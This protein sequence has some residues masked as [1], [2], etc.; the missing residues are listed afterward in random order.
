LLEAR[1]SQPYAFGASWTFWHENPQ[2]P[3]FR[4]DPRTGTVRPSRAR[5]DYG[6]VL[7]HPVSVAWR[8]LDKELYLSCFQFRQFSV[9]QRKAI[10]RA[11]PPY[12][13]NNNFLLWY[14]RFVSVMMG[15]GLYVPPAQT[16]RDGDPLGIWFADLPVHV[17][18]DV[19][20]VFGDVLASLLRYKSTGLILDP[21]L[22][23]IVHQH[24][25]G[26]EAIYDLLVHAG[27]PSLQ[28]YPS[29][30][31]EP[32]QHPD[33]KL[34]DYCLAW[35]VYTL[36]RALHGEYLSDRYFMQ[37]F[38]SNMHRSLQ[39]HVREWLEQAV[40]NTFVHDPLSHTFSPD[41]LFTKILERVRHLGQEKLALDSPRDSL[42][43]TQLV[44]A[45][46]IPLPDDP[47]DEFLIAAVASSTARTCFL[48]AKDHLLISCPLLTDLQKDPFRRK[49]LLRALGAAVPSPAPTGGS[50]QVR[51]V[52][53]ASLSDPAPTA[54]LPD[55]ASGDGASASD[56]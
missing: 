24:D 46:T 44:R 48:C 38:L 51:A 31:T 30:P 21:A 27:H 4:V 10:F 17:Q 13:E 5:V 37:Q 26:Y 18:V 19:E 23:Q 14:S 3:N 8:F 29:L 52:L 6:V 32:R 50:K 35:N 56:F 55:G 47:D 1:D 20:N 42:R 40:T 28:A 49:A 36:Q 2:H 45:V 9:D 12:G 39:A 7:C 43:S 16:M 33:C 11:V 22:S 15:F 41:R 54:A 25:N 34:S 53:D